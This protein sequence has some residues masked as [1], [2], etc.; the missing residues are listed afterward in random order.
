MQDFADMSMEQLAAIITT[1]LKQQDIQVVLVGGLAVSLYTDN[2]YLTKD[3]DIVDISYQK[4]ATLKAAMADIGFYKQG[5][6][7]CN[8]ST[9]ITVEF[10]SAPLSVGDEPITEQTNISTEHGDIPVLYAVD[11]VKDRLAAY[12]HWQDQQSLVQALCVMLC[13]TIKPAE[14]KAFCEKE[15]DYNQYGQ[16]NSLYKTL[17]QRGIEEMVD[18]EQLIIAEQLK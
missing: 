5:R 6:V 17:K 15:A 16:I 8:D 3:I 13:H 11:I 14:V 4:P 7:Y 10:P 9:D 12:F 1:H 18:I 2:R